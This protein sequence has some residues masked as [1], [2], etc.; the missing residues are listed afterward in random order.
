MGLNMINNGLAEE[1]VLM[2]ANTL[3]YVEKLHNEIDQT[4]EEHQ[5]VLFIRIGKVFYSKIYRPND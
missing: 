5:A 1:V 3:S 2:G 4:P